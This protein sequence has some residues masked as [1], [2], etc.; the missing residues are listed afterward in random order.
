[1]ACNVSTLKSLLQARIHKHAKAKTLIIHLNRLRRLPPLP[2]GT[3]MVT[4]DVSSLYTNIPHDEGI[5]N[6]RGVP[7]FTRAFWYLLQLTCAILSG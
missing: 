2:P 5:K 3:L 7:E 6:L 1:M 4:L